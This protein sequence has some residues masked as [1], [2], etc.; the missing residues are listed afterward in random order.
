MV[1]AGLPLTY[2]T[3]RSWSSARRLVSD[4]P[5]AFPVV[6]HNGAVEV[7][8]GTGKVLVRRC[9]P[10]TV[11][12][13]VLAR[14]RVAGLSPLVHTFDDVERV[15]WVP[16]GSNRHI[17][18]FWAERPGDPRQYPVGRWDL[19]PRQGVICLAV[20]G[21]GDEIDRLAIELTG[22]CPGISISLRPDRTR[23]ETMWLEVLPAAISKGHAVLELG[24]RLRLDRLIVFG[25]DVNDLTMFERADEVY[26]V[27]NA[28][29]DIK[30]LATAVIGSNDEDGVA[31]QLER[32][33]EANSSEPPV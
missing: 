30:A 13:G 27:A 14:C 21:G 33:L 16:P 28:A 2:A 29:D 26:V 1:A 24:R 18:G 9:F 32:L 31:A 19:L 12:D 25:D 8:P 3:A 15:M 20:L 6:L 23:P 10:E 7:D 5:F 22:Q 4:A 11:I 17:A